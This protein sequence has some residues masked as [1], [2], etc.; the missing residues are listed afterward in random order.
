MTLVSQ[1]YSL[2]VLFN[3][4]MLTSKGL[5]QYG[6]V[7]VLQLNYLP[8]PAQRLEMLFQCK[9]LMGLLLLSFSLQLGIMLD[10]LI[11][12]QTWYV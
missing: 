9:Q 3:V 6:F 5:E 11:L 8:E 7:T 12:K 4:L 1:T 10:I 2:H